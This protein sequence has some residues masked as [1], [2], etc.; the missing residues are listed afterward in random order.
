MSDIL[1]VDD[2]V[3]LARSIVSFM[4]RRGFSASYAVDSRG[5][6]AMALR[7]RPRLVLLDVR[8]G[9]ENGLD[10][11]GWFK[12][13][14]PEA[15]IVVMTAHGEI[16]IAVDAMKRGARDFLTKPA[17]LS[18]IASIAAN[19]ML[20]DVSRPADARGVDRILGRSS[21]AVDLRAAVRRLAPQ[22]DALAPPSAVLVSGPPAAGKATVA[23]AFYETAKIQRGLLIEAD[24]T[25]GGAQLDTALARTGGTILLRHVDALSHGDQVR[26]AQAMAA[27]N[28][29]WVLATTSCNLAK[30][31]RDGGFRA[32]LLYR[33]QVAWIEVPPLSE[34]TSDILPIAEAFARQ[35]AFR[36]GRDRPRLT[37]A[38]R[39]RLVEH[40]WPGNLS[41]LENCMERAVLS[42]GNKAIDA[43]DI[44]ILTSD[45]SEAHVPNLVQMEAVALNKALSA[46]HGNVTRAAVLLG[47]SRDTLR[48]RIAKYDI[49][50]P[51]R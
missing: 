1:V 14:A 45:D 36:D 29:P 30:L 42:A 27:P 16:G 40:D 19:L 34:R 47:I 6:M 37:P 10:L 22:I 15:Q 9:R 38:A 17:P 48:Y 35:A 46:T 28:A 50:R 26:L 39:V 7:D 12:T 2:E 32:D 49:S 4:E 31:E 44:Q 11:L 8:L 18:T 3:V 13:E 33:I 5:A 20:D 23:R 51:H 41:E 24:C 21:S 43:S 25:L